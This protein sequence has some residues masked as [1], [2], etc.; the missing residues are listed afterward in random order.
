MERAE[1]VRH[2]IKKAPVEG[3]IYI[4]IYIGASRCRQGFQIYSR[5]QRFR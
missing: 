3:A 4:Y 5:E 1:A 2:K